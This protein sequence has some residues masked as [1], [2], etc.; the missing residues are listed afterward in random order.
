[1]AVFSEKT[2]RNVFSLRIKAINDHIRIAFMTSSKYDNLEVL[3]KFFQA[4]NCIRPNID[5]CIDSS[6]IGEGDLQSNIIGHICRLIAVDQSFIK[7]KYDCF[8]VGG[9]QIDWLLA[10][11]WH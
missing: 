8:A 3:T 4:L 2:M 1:M 7:V 10:L 5:S 9:W 11:F 6:I